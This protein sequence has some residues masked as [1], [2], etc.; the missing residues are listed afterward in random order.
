MFRI[1]PVIVTWFQLLVLTPVAFVGANLAL[2]IIIGVC[3]L[4]FK[5]IKPKELIPVIY[6]Y[7]LPDGETADRAARSEVVVGGCVV[8]PIDAVCPHCR[9]PAR[10]R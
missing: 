2:H 6:G 7:A 9:W 4:H 5:L 8:T 1:V 10:L 3:P